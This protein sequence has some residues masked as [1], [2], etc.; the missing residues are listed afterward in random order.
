MPPVE[1]TRPDNRINQFLAVLPPVARNP[2]CKA[3]FYGGDGSYN[4]T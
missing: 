3:W 2:G 4:A 1:T